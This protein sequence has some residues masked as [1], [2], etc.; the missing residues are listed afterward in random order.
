MG[1][2]ILCAGCGGED[3]KVQEVPADEK[4]Y[5]EE[6][7]LMHPDA[8]KAEFRQYIE[9]AEKELDMKIHLLASPINADN[10]HARISTILSSG[11]DSVDVI[12]VNDEMINEFKYQGYLEPLGMM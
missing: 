3:H 5:G 10:R 12:A 7:T 11:D 1:A 8:D 2:G 4:A 6:I 9:A